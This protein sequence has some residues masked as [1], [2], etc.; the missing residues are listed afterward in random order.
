MPMRAITLIITKGRCA[1]D[2]G[3]LEECSVEAITHDAHN[4]GPPVEEPQEHYVWR[5][6]MTESLPDSDN[7]KRCSD[8]IRSVAAHP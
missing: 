5:I 4:F 7:C 6:M 2:V 3:D 8:T 1:R